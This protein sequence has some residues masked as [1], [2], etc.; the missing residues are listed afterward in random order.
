MNYDVPMIL[1]ANVGKKCVILEYFQ[2]HI[3]ST[4]LAEEIKSQIPNLFTTTS[5]HSQIENL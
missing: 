1:F 4:E 5:R 3:W 2:K